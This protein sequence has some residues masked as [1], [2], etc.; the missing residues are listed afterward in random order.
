MASAALLALW[1][2]PVGHAGARPMSLGTGPDKDLGPEI[3]PSI[4]WALASVRLVPFPL[5]KPGG[6]RIDGG[7]ARAE[8]VCVTT[9]FRLLQPG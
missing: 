9:G 2:P 3:V 6:V 5:L 7:R 1:P 8:H 4:V